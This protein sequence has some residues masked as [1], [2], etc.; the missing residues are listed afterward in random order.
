MCG[1]MVLTH[2]ADE[3]ARLFAGAAGQRPAGESFNVCPT[4]DVPVV[5]PGEARRLVAKRWGPVP[6]WAKAPTDG[7]LLIFRRAALDNW[8]RFER[9]ILQIY[10]DADPIAPDAQHW[11]AEQSAAPP[12]VRGVE[13]ANHSFYGLEMGTPGLRVDRKL[14][15]RTV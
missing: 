11:Y 2:A 10:G 14:A 8:K 7:P 4:Q 6:R 15:G 5:V 9:P 1:R 3:M 12:L 13:G